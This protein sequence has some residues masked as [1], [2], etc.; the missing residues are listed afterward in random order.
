MEDIKFTDLNVFK[1]VPFPFREIKV[2]L[3][4]EELPTFTVDELYD[5]TIFGLYE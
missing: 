1:F 2:G 3:F 4:W 5:V